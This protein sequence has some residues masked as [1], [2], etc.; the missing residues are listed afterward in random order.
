M[1]VGN[2]LESM[3]QAMLVGIM[4]VGRLGVHTGRKQAV[5][6]MHGGRDSVRW[7][8]MCLTL[9]CKLPVLWFAIMILLMVVFQM[10][11]CFERHEMA[12]AKRLE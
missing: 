1:S 6:E 3:S 12:C 4:L 5:N 10:C 2:L 8:G 11:Q 7:K 9:V